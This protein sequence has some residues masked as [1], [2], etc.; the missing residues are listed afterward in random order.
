M[1]GN[2]K[3][4]KEAQVCLSYFWAPSSWTLDTCDTASGIT[5]VFWHRYI[6]QAMCGDD[7]TIFIFIY[8]LDHAPAGVS[9]VIHSSSDYPSKEGES[10]EMHSDL[11]ILRCAS[12]PLC[13]SFIVIREMNDVKEEVC[14]LCSQH[15]TWQREREREFDSSQWSEASQRHRQCQSWGTSSF[16]DIKSLRCLWR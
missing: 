9:R 1:G 10:R 12:E 16:L 8:F 15:L 7:I 5:T 13:P 2:G 4:F 6:Q 14:L 11:S 3:S